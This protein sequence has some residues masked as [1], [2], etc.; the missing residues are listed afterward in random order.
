MAFDISMDVQ[1]RA[2]TVDDYDR[3]IELWNS[4][5]NVGLGPSDTRCSIALFLKRNPGLSKVMAIDGIVVATL[6][7]GHDGRRGYLYHLCV[8]KRHRRKSVGRR[9]VDACLSELKRAG[10][11]KCHLFVFDRNQPGKSFWAATAWSQRTD[12]EVFSKDT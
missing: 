9:L 3:A 11:Q 5:E 2:F 1:I 12:I 10:I 7:C 8:D 4:E 6:L